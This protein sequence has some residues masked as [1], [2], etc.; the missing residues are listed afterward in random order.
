MVLLWSALAIAVAFLGAASFYPALGLRPSHRVAVLIGL[1]TVVALAPWMI[2]PEERFARFSA[3]FVTVVLLLKMWDVHIGAYHAPP[4]SLR[5]FLKF[6]P[7]FFSFVLRRQGLESQPTPR[8][9]WTNLAR[10]LAT[11]ISALAVLFMLL[12]V[13]WSSVP[14]LLEHVLKATAFFVF[15]AASFDPLRRTGRTN[16]HACV[17]GEPALRQAQIERPF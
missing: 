2:S 4:P 14:F 5:R 13:D 12:S 1:G 3:A 17:C 10:S 7:N 15:M 11:A 16:F 9:N 8:G 6:L